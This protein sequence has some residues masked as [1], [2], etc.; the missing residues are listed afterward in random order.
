MKNNDIEILTE[1]WG[2]AEGKEIM[3]YTLSNNHGMSLKISNYGAIVQSVI[4][5]DKNDGSVNIVLGYDSLADY[6]ADTFYIGAVVGRY[7]SRIAG[8]QF[9]I[10]GKI[11]QLTQNN[12]TIC[13]HGGLHGFNKKVF[14]AAIF[15]DDHLAGIRFSYYSPD[16]EE[17]FP[18]NL[19]FQVTYSITENN[20]WIVSYEATTDKDTVINFTQH[21][22]FNF[23]GREG[24]S[25]LDHELAV[26]ADHY[27]PV[28]ELFLPTGE[29]MPVAHTQ[30]D[31]RK[32]IPVKNNLTL[33]GTQPTAAMGFDYSWVL[34]K[35]H[36][37][38]LKKAAEVYEPDSGISMEVFTTEPSVHFYSGIFLN[39]ISADNDN[40]PLKK[41]YGFCLETQHF[42]DSPNQLHFPSTLLQA[43]QLFTS[44]T[45]FKFL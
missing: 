10:D 17:G 12:G 32:M 41:R 45:V 15:Q 5:P 6:V 28:D 23:K 13:L 38:A 24:G 18:G 34:E 42:P 2:Y 35:E 1:H 20:E 25:I 31:F 21:S 26:Y 29:I 9:V 37:S 11:C 8:G 4:V 14:D 36:S 7:A 33:P 44:K 43:S 40:Q 3:L 30:F 27:L 16:G 22:Y 39:D 19:Q